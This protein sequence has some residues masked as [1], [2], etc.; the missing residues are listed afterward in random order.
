MKIRH[1]AGP[2]E[3]PGPRLAPE[4]RKVGPCRQAAA[5]SISMKPQMF[6]SGSLA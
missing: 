5:G 2:G 6:P 3:P 1:G 4:G